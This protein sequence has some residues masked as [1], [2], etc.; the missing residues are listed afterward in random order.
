MRDMCICYGNEISKSRRHRLHW[1]VLSQKITAVVHDVHA[2]MM[3]DNR[4]M[5]RIF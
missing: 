4:A 5:R 3:L 2:M 1:S